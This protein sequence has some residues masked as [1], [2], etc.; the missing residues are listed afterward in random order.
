MVRDDLIIIC[1]IG[2]IFIFLGIAAIVWSKMEESSWYAS[3]AKRVD[4]REFLDRVP[5]RPEPGSLKI[6][7]RICIVVGILM[8]MVSLGLYLWGQPPV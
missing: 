7:G 5:K 6:G 4:V 1:I 3:I 8:L 2:G